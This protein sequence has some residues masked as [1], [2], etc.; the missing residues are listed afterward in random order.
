[1]LLVIAVAVSTA[2]AFGRELGL[3][4]TGGGLWREDVDY[5][6]APLSRQRLFILL[7]VGGG[8]VGPLSKVDYW[9]PQ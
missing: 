1:M 3:L 4:L 8:F 7:L 9:I 2:F 5:F 6:A